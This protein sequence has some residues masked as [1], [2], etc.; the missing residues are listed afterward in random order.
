VLDLSGHHIGRSWTAH[1][2]EDTCPC[3]QADCGLVLFDTIDPACPEHHWSAAKS[4]RQT[5]PATK[6]KAARFAGEAPHA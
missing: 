6:C 2:V 4:I 3:P 1:D 5:H